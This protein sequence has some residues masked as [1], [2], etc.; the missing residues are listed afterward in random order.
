MSKPILDT[1]RGRCWL[2]QKTNVP[3]ECHHVFNGNPNRKRSEQYG[4]KIYLCDSCHK[5]IHADQ[6]LDDAVKAFMQEHAMMHY[7]W[8]VE[9]FSKIFGKNYI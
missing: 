8:E 9:D 4:L 1:K 5:K 7:G 2:C 3:T 6:E